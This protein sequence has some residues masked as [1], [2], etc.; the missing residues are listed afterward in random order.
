MQNV[1]NSSSEIYIM[2][3]FS[4]IHE[5]NMKDSKLETFWVLGSLKS[6]KFCLLFPI[7]ASC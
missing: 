5:I 1:R 7:H 4:G 3:I 6:T 2:T